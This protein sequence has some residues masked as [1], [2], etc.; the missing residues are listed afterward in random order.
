[1]TDKVGAVGSTVTGAGHTV[2]DAVTDAVGGAVGGARARV[3]DLGGFLKDQ[4]TQ[5]RMSL[6]QLADVAGV[7]NPYL[8]QVERGLRHPSAEV[9]QQLARALRI[10][11]EALYVRAGLLEE[12]EPSPVPAA[13]TSD[14]R[15]T[16]RQKRVLLDVYAS[17][18][19]E[20][21]GSHRPDQTAADDLT[22]DTDTDTD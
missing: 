12:G 10:S 7:S 3:G 18:V 19:A 1:M 2:T 8:S 21:T 15:L 20:E 9:L 16:E 5:A 6:R 11:A 4:R 22:P 13:V 14:P 17:F